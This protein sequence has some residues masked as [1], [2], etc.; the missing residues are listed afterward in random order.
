MRQKLIPKQLGKLLV[1]QL[2]MWNI[3]VQQQE[4]GEVIPAH[5]YMAEATNLQSEFSW[6]WFNGP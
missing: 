5:I 4:K 1:E 3:P 6:S 2:W